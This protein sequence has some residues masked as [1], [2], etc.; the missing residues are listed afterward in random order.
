MGCLCEGVTG[1]G[2]WVAGTA[3]IAQTRTKV[4]DKTLIN[5]QIMLFGHSAQDEDVHIY[6][7]ACQ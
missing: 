6:Y 3:Q 7:R 5:S 2:G 1:K 4:G